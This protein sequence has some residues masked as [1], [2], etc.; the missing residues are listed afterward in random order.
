MNESIVR[1]IREAPEFRTGDSGVTL[2]GHF[3]MFDEWTEIT[4]SYEGRFMESISPGAFTKTMRENREAIK[5][6]FNHG[7]DGTVDNKVLGQIIDLE[8]DGMGARY[9]VA[10][11]DTSYNRDLVPG[12][13]AGVYGASFRFEPLKDKWEEQPTRSDHNPDGLPE[14]TIR[15]V[16]LH[17][18]GPVTFPAYAGATAG[19]RSVSLTDDYRRSM[20][21]GDTD[22]AT[23][24]R[25]PA[26]EQKPTEPPAHFDG[27]TPAQRQKALRQFYL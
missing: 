19:V 24:D 18:F 11:F 22:P 23:P 12:L 13:R 5:V 2:A 16:R 25:E 15:E 9:A 14:R 27:L 4:S 21:L 8:E 20:R 17:E 6:L 1:A 26:P 7:M 3:A 10:L